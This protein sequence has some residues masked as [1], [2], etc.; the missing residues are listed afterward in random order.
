MLKNDS[1]I[2][3][4]GRASLLRFLSHSNRLPTAMSLC[5]RSLLFASPAPFDK[6][7]SRGPFINREIAQW[8]PAFAGEAIQKAV[9]RQ[10]QNARHEAGR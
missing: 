3:L 1:R 10:K 7:R 5:L 6:L 2:D 4:M 8:T 9:M